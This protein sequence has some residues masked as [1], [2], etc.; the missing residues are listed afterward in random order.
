MGRPESRF[1]EKLTKLQVERLGQTRDY[2]A[3]K[4]VRQRAHAILLSFRGTSINELVKIFSTSRNTI[5]SWLDRWEAKKFNGLAD[6]QRPGAPAKLALEEQVLA[7]NLLKQT[8]R[9]SNTVLVE[10]EKQTGKQI[11]SAT[12]KR[13]AKRNKLIWKRMRKSLRSKRDQKKFATQA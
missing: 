9:S 12:L 5:C 1:I 3:S 4:R 11:S 7:L 13:L 8:P 6:R 2:D 10:L